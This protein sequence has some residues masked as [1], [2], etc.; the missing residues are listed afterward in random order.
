MSRYL[1]QLLYESQLCVKKQVVAQPIH[2]ASAQPIVIPKKGTVL[3]ELQQYTL[4]SHSEVQPLTPSA[5]NTYLD[6]SLRFYFQYLARI[7]V[8]TQ[9]QPATHALVFG[10]LLHKVMEK[11]YTPLMTRKQGKPLQSKDLSTLQKKIPTVVKAV[12][13]SMFQHHQ[14]AGLPGDHA[15][16]QAVMIKLVNRILVL[17]QAYAPF[18]LIGLE[19]G[20]QAPLSFDFTLNATTYVR[21]QGIID[22]VDWKDGVVRVLDYKTGMDEKKLK[23]I[24][25]LFDRAFFKGNRAAFQTFFYAWLFQ[26]KS[27]SYASNT[28]FLPVSKTS[29][30]VEAK[31]MPGLLN[32]RQLF[33]ADFDPRFFLQ[34]PGRRTYS[35]IEDIATHR[36]DWEAGLRTTLSELLDPI[37]PFSQTDDVTRCTSCPYKGICERR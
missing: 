37:V 4:Q 30:S 10:N 27:L 19:M 16:A 9:P 12:F 29:I 32:T 18:V 28:S 25:S 22:R 7:K 21:L 20:R 15:I 5:L 14:S 35:P 24:P 2:L 3:H 8:S 17:D 33:N 11:L 31:V 23:D 34:Q 36:Q 6:C 26:Q 1:L 13:S